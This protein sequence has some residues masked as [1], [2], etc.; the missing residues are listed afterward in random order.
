MASQKFVCYDTLGWSSTVLLETV[1]DWL[2][3]IELETY[4]QDEADGVE[5][6][7]PNVENVNKWTILYDSPVEKLQAS[8]T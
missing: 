5:N 2:E 4:E 7:Y 3:I 8:T 1:R 6:R